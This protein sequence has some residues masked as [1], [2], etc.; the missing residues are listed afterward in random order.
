MTTESH[1]T[2]YLREG[3]VVLEDAIPPDCLAEVCESYEQ[4]LETALRLE[5]VQRDEDTGF[6]K[7]Y[8]F[9]DPHH[10]AL[11]RYPLMDALGAPEILSFAHKLYPG[12]V[13]MHGAA[14]FAMNDDYDYKGPWHRDS[15]YLWGK[16][17]A[18]EKQ[19]REDVNAPSTQVLIALEDDDAFWFVPG[20]HNRANTVEE[21]A[22]FVEERTSSQ[23]MF[24]G[25]IQLQVRAGS[26][27]P[28]DWRGIHRGVK[29][30][31]KRRRSLFAVYGTKE[32][33]KHAGISK[34]A[35]ESEYSEPKYLE[36]LPEPFRQSVENTIEALQ[37]ES[38][39]E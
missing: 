27:V 3:Y 18:M 14:A 11:A 12:E 31:G 32:G 24:P 30:P 7:G 23:E 37:T 25:A 5:M 9:Q 38:A 4:T 19:V 36:S 21:E 16:D 29:L 13:A 33:V 34:W 8:R 10:P 26:A 39:G 1:T 15:Y 6:L 2:T 28:F 22:H 35:L 20:S 17:S